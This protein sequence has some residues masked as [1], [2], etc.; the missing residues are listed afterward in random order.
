MSSSKAPHLVVVEDEPVTRTLL[1]AY[2][3]REGFRISQA[4]DGPAM[5]RALPADLVLLDVDLPGE[6]GFHLARELRARSDV[7][8]IFLTRMAD[9]V[10]RITGLELGA[11]DY[12]VKPPDMRELMARVK[13]LLRRTSVLAEDLPRFQAWALDRGRQRLLSPSGESVPLTLGELH[14]ISALVDAGGRI[15]P[16]NELVAAVGGG[17]KR[18]LDVLINRLRRKLGEGGNVVPTLILTVHGVGYQL[19]VEVT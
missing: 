16:R 17:G 9:A 10:D 14:I 12:V 3:E 7:G 13:N 1:A 2:L 5:R 19:G 4:A 11:D 15:V 18:S 6:D 8:I